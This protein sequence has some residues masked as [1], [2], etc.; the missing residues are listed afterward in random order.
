MPNLLRSRELAHL[1]AVVGVIASFGLVVLPSSGSSVTGG[2]DCTGAGL[3]FCQYQELHPC[4]GTGC[5]SLMYPG[6]VGGMG[7][8]HCQNATMQYCQAD[9]C[10]TG[11][12][13]CEC[14]PQ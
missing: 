4:V 2:V 6:C 3:N 8:S 9:N 12:T 14:P 11:F 13:P 10:T 7:G 5:G 1:S